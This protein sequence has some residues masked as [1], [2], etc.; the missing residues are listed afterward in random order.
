MCNLFINL[1]FNKKLN[2]L[3]LT[4]L[5]RRAKVGRVAPGDVQ[6]DHV[7]TGAAAAGAT[8][9]SRSACAPTTSSSA[10]YPAA[11]SPTGHGTGRAA[12]P[13]VALKVG[14]PGAGRAPM[15]DAGLGALA[16]RVPG[17]GRVRAA[18]VPPVRGLT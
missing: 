4:R 18:V 1:I 2:I 6:V 13:R 11:G 14:R 7:G 10:T 17:R 3:I 12:E 8:V 9:A 15:L 16:V 5:P